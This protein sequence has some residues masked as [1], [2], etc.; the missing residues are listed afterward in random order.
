MPLLA[1]ISG[2][3]SFSLAIILP[4]LPALAGVHGTDY[5]GIQFLVSA[6]LLGLALSQPLWGQVTDRI[7]R[8][9][10]VLLGFTVYVAA[11][12]ACLVAEAWGLPKG[13]CALVGRF[14]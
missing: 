2:L 10:V 7:G 14:L 1:V 3:S 6:Y 11:S 8:R 5:A 9:P 13:C 4:A 12:L